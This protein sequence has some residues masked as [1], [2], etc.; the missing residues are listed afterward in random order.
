MPT[1]TSTRKGSGRRRVSSKKTKKPQKKS[2]SQLLAAVRDSVR[3][4]LGRQTD[5]VWGLVLLV[6]AILVTLAFFR[7]A[8]PVGFVLE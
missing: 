4:T 6:L 8:G 3:N 5:D 1:R 7:L 2:F